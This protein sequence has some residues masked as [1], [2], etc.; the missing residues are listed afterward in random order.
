MVKPYS[1]GSADCSN[2][3]IQLFAAAAAE[4]RQVVP[5]QRMAVWA[6]LPGRGWFVFSRL[7]ALTASLVL[8]PGCE[9]AR[10]GLHPSA[11]ICEQPR[12]SLNSLSERGIQPAFCTLK[13]DHKL[14]TAEQIGLVQ[15]SIFG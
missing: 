14:I 4:F 11:I 3:G 8:Q 15:F 9:G 5:G 1:S 13:D 7:Q 12:L 10:G 2:A 6:P